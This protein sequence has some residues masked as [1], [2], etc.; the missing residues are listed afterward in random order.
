M[1]L[2]VLR[3]SF[4]QLVGRVPIP[5]ALREEYADYVL[6]RQERITLPAVIVG[7]AIMVGLFGLDISILPDILGMAADVR[8]GVVLPVALALGIYL[9]RDTRPIWVHYAIGGGTALLYGTLACILVVSSYAPLAPMYLTANNVTVM[10]VVLIL[11][12]PPALAATMAVAL[13]VIQAAILS[14]SHAASATLLFMMTGISV[15]IAAAGLYGNIR[16]DRDR[17]L[18][19]LSKQRDRQHLRALASQNALLERLSALDPLTGLS[20][21]RGL[22][23]VMTSAIADAQA[24]PR[25]AV[26]AVAMVD[27]DHFKLFNDSQGHVAGDEALCEVA[28]ALAGAVAGS[29]LVARYG[30]E[31]FA[32]VMPEAE[33]LAL[34]MAGARLRAAVNKMNLVH[35]SSS[36]A[37]TVTVSIGIAYADRTLLPSMTPQILT[38]AA[39]SALYEAKSGG[40]DRVVVRACKIEPEPFK[41]SWN[42]DAI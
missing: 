21:R 11:E 18:Q 1:N 8:F 15:S 33:P 26:V 40:R 16:M 4:G 42:K 5:E 10:F 35:P 38:E 29:D 32:I 3:S 41:I 24:N 17:R 39:D 37:R 14:M 25:T 13:I 30:G 31:E 9:Y 20:N 2:N 27:I 36:T 12:Y 28:E 7:T 22:D 23:A 6:K 19:F 34:E